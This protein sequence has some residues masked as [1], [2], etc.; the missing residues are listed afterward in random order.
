MILYSRLEEK[1]AAALAKVQQQQTTNTNEVVADNDKPVI[2]SVEKA[3]D[4][5]ST[6]HVTTNGVTSSEDKT[7]EKNYVNHQYLAP[8]IPKPLNMERRRRVS[9]IHTLCGE[10]CKPPI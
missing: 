3:E 5:K 2:P 9:T 6:N 1:R 7:A 8:V 4:N 10:Y